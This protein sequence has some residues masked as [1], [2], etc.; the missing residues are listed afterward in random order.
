MYDIFD[1]EN[2]KLITLTI[3]MSAQAGFLRCIEIYVPKNIIT[4]ILETVI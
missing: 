1:G 2:S 3:F 4:L